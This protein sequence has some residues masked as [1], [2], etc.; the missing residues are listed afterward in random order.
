ALIAQS[1]AQAAA[2]WSLRE[3]L[4]EAN[5]RIGAIAS[6]DVSLPLSE[7]PGFIE[8][9]GRMV[10]ARGDVRVNCF[11]HLGD[12]NLHYNLFPVPG[13]SRADYPD[14]AELARGVHDLVMAR[15]GSFSAE[16]GIGRLKTAE[17]VRWADP[18]RL[19]AMRAVKAALDPLGIMN[20]GAVLA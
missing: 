6:H 4:P 8:A 14:A 15:G 5:R 12:G 17:L 13:R 11:G 7:I 9:A 19:A 18:A 10:A 3:S 16:H 2:F 1:G 20:P